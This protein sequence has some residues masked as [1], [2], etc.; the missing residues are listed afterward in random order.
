M[1]EG[2]VLIEQ[3]HIDVIKEQL[4]GIRDILDMHM[5][6]ELVDFHFKLW[7]SFNKIENATNWTRECDVVRGDII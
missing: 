5:D 3:Q 6:T 4:R 7:G 2:Y 1:I